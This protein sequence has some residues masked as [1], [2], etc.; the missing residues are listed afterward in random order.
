VPGKKRAKAMAELTRDLAGRPRQDV[1]ASFMIT[2]MPIS[3]AI[4]IQSPPSPQS[5][6]NDG[7]ALDY[8][9]KHVGVSDRRAKGP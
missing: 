8:T 3:F 1:R 2:V 5:M 9:R 6:I 4:Q 7:I